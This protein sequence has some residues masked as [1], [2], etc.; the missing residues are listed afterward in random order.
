MFYNVILTKK[1][2]IVNRKNWKFMYCLHLNCNFLEVGVEIC[3]N[4]RKAIRLKELRSGKNVCDN[5]TID[6]TDEMMYN[7]TVLNCNL[8]GYLHSSRLIYSFY[9]F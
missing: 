9:M 7:K 5:A 2:Y 3:K 1:I 4:M 6:K 8:T